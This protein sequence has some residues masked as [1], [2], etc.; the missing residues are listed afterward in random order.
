MS[1]QKLSD[2]IFQGQL[3]MEFCPVMRRSHESQYEIQLL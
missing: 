2:I 3:G 1:R